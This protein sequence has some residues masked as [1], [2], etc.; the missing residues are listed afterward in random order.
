MIKK[1]LALILCA[2][3]LLP[4]FVACDKDDDVPEG[5]QSVT[6]AGEP[7]I[8]YVPQDWIDNRDSGIS[9]AYYSLE[10]SIFAS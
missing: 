3:I 7:F 6:L 8:F 1:I 2:V 5:M 4:I 9:A 10:K